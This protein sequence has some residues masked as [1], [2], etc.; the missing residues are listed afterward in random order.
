[1]YLSFEYIEHY[2]TY[3][4]N[5]CV[6]VCVCFNSDTQQRNNWQVLYPNLVCAQTRQ[7]YCKSINIKRKKLK[8]EGYVQ[9]FKKNENK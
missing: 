1:M 2:L 5:I 8:G 6:H 7:E 4:Q 9:L 3:H